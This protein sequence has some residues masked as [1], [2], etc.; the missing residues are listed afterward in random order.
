MQMTSLEPQ[1]VRT[2]AKG[3]ISRLSRWLRL[4]KTT[5]VLS[6]DS[7]EDERASPESSRGGKGSQRL[8]LQQNER[9][10]V[11]EKRPGKGKKQVDRD[12]STPAGVKRLQV[13]PSSSS[14]I[15]EIGLIETVVGQEAAGGTSRP[16]SLG[17]NTLRPPPQGIPPPL[18]FSGQSL[19]AGF[20][21]QQVGP[22]EIV[23]LVSTSSDASYFLQGRLSKELRIGRPP[24]SQVDDNALLLV[25]GL[26]CT[27]LLFLLSGGL[28]AVLATTLVAVLLTPLAVPSVLTP[29]KKRP[30]L[31]V[32]IPDPSSK[33]PEILP[34]PLQN[35]PAQRPPPASAPIPSFRPRITTPSGLYN[36]RHYP[37]TSFSTPKSRTPP[38]DLDIGEPVSVKNRVSL[39]SV[40]HF[41]SASVPISG[42]STPRQTPT[43]T[44][45]SNRSVKERSFVDPAPGE[46]PK[47]PAAAAF[48][49]RV[50]SLGKLEGVQV[51]QILVALLA[52]LF[53]SRVTAVL[54]LVILCL[55]SGVQI[56]EEGRCG[57]DEPQALSPPVTGKSSTRKEPSRSELSNSWCSPLSS[58]LGTFSVRNPAKSDSGM[59]G[60]HSVPT[61]LP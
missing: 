53:W 11:S 49:N 61:L 12:P 19:P 55:H 52:T 35:K 10:G 13:A 28:V 51:L 34:T 2:P 29:T 17:V 18:L 50:K 44:P 14:E 39:G 42:R 60:R 4:R 7:S 37:A 8:S 15:E 9:K 54:G 31:T 20:V 3:P 25:A 27:A 32:A 21:P 41:S 43:P 5:P 30:S 22:A 56:K 59:T 46:A 48:G 6:P 26:L 47:W 1:Q 33:S 57:V 45:L 36:G 40:A 38:P 58:P 16:S 23:P 24:E